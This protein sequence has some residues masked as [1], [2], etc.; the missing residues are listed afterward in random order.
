MWEG[1]SENGAVVE[2]AI[3]DGAA[4]AFDDAFDHI[5]SGAGAVG[6]SF[7]GVAGAGEFLP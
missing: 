5:E 7:L 2:R 4:V 1:K 6:A 3:D